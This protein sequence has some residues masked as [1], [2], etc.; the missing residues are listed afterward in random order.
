MSGFQLSMIIHPEKG[1]ISQPFSG[2]HFHIKAAAGNQRS[3][4]CRFSR[5]N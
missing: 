5:T 3:V 1:C 2:F 4:H